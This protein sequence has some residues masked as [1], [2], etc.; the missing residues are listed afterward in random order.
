[1]TGRPPETSA[2]GEPSGGNQGMAELKRVYDKWQQLKAELARDA[3]THQRLGDDQSEQGTGIQW[4]CDKWDRANQ[5]WGSARAL[6][7]AR[8]RMEQLEAG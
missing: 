1:V 3:D 7:D 5:H 8:Q 2:D 4:D 6:R